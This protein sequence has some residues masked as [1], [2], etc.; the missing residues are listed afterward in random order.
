MKRVIYEIA[1]ALLAIIAVSLAIYNLFYEMLAWQMIVDNCILIVFIVDYF[2]RLIVTKNRKK[3][4]KENILDLIAIIPFNSAFKIFRIAKLAKLA[5]ISRITKL[6]KVLAYSA[7]VHKKAKRFFDT[8][9]F[10]YMVLITVCLIIISGILIH[11]AENMSF[12]DGIWWAFVTATT[13]GYGDISPGTAGGRA[14]AIVLMIAG[15]GLIGSLT[16]T[17]TSYF[18]NVKE[19]KTVR[20]EIM[21]QIK[22][23]LDNI[24]QL[25][26][27]DIDTLCQV[28]NSY[29]NNRYNA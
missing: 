15:I 17:I 28:I 20:N 18:F 13:V 19:K 25:S 2:I 23:Q 10:K 21:E 3:F 9:G 6:S 26:D 12:Q 22:G 4:F 11:F 24:E 1:M 5:R 16:S 27:E 14:I 29:K 8:N 7:R